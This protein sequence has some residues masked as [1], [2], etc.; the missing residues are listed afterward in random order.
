M[1]VKPSINVHILENFLGVTVIFHDLPN[2]AGQPRAGLQLQFL[3]R[4][5]IPMPDPSQ[6][7][8]GVRFRSGDHRR[9][10][11]APEAVPVTVARSLNVL[12]APLPFVPR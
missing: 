2:V 11:C 1:G 3:E 8:F 10:S 5:F 4:G 6:Q 7:V 9:S 12:V